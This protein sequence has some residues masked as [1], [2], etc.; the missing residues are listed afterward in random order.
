[1]KDIKS[2]VLILIFHCFQ[3]LH[4]LVEISK[5][6]RNY[7]RG[8]V[9]ILIFLMSSNIASTDLHVAK[10]TYTNNLK[11]VS[12]LILLHLRYQTISSR[13]Q[14]IAVKCILTSYP[15]KIDLCTR[16]TL[17]IFCVRVRTQIQVL[18]KEEVTSISKRCV[19]FSCDE[20]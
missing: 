14:Y 4:F 13:M 1:M 9:K 19:T 12:Q 15:Q 8:C 2:F 11:G 18:F 3:R 10:S 20:N 17:V 5:G 6:G 7:A 16:M